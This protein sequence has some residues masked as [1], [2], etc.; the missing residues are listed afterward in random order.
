VSFNGHEY[1]FTDEAGKQLTKDGL[2]WRAGQVFKAAGLPAPDPHTM[3]HTLR[4]PLTTRTSRTAR[5]R[6]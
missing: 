2:A 5:S 6:K 1:V 3:R 4:R